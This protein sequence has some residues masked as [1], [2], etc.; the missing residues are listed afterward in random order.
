[1]QHEQLQHSLY[2]RIASVRV[3][4]GGVLG[5]FITNKLALVGYEIVLAAHS[6]HSLLL[7][8]TK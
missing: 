1:M 5:E 3:L 2:K 7:Y 4:S 6:T 8:S